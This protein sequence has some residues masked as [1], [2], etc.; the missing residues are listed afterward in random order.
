VR[1]ANQLSIQL[2][3]PAPAGF[4]GANLSASLTVR[5][6]LLSRSLRHSRAKSESIHPQ[7]IQRARSRRS[8]SSN[9]IAPIVAVIYTNGSQIDTSAQPLNTQTRVLPHSSLSSH[10]PT[11]KTSLVTQSSNVFFAQLVD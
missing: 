6:K 3:I 10:L 4:R 7:W 11:S 8:T 2:R 9:P 5:A 1:A